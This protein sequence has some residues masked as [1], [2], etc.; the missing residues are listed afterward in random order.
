MS[1]QTNDLLHIWGKSLRSKTALLRNGSLLILF[2]YIGMRS[3]PA[4]CRR[5]TRCR[6][7]WQTVCNRP[8]LNFCWA[9]IRWD[10]A[11]CL[12]YCTGRATP[13]CRRQWCC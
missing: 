7:M 4:H 10:A 8:Q 12:G 11:F 9:P 1:C 5:M 2:S 6:S 3:L 13:C